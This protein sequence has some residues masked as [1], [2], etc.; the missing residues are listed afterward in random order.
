MGKQDSPVVNKHLI[1]KK[2]PFD[3]AGY[4][5]V[6]MWY[7]IVLFDPEVVSEDGRTQ[8]WKEVGS[9]VSFEQV[10]QSP[11]FIWDI[12]FPNYTNWVGI[13]FLRAEDGLTNLQAYLF[14]EVLVQK[15]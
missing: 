10:N 5:C 14:K 3:F 4:F 11:F 8:S 9:T 7:L 15:Y 12:F 6:W 1:K 13:L 2:K